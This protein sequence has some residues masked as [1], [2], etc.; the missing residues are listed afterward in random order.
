MTEEEDIR[1]PGVTSACE[2]SEVGAL[3]NTGPLE[4]S[5]AL[6]TAEPSS[7]L[8]NFVFL[9]WLESWVTDA[10]DSQADSQNPYQQQIVADEPQQGS[11]YKCSRM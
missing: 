5:Q 8:D 6:R 2:L 4:K 1:S 3:I 11:V 7:C 9:V 10:V